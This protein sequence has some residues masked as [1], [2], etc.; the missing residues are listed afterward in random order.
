MHLEQK[1]KKKFTPRYLETA[2]YVDW[3]SG[4]M[5]GAAANQY[6]SRYTQGRQQSAKSG[7]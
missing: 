3:T 6:H 1:K 5:L 7:T 4:V 2:F